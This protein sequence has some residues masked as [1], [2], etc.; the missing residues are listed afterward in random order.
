MLA[1][2]FCAIGGW[3]GHGAGGPCPHRTR[4]RGRPDGLPTKMRRVFCNALCFKIWP[5]ILKTLCTASEPIGHKG[6]TLF[7]IPKPGAD[8]SKCVGSRGVLAQ[9]ALA[10]VA[11]K[12]TR[13]I[14]VE[15][16]EQTGQSFRIGG[17]KGYCAGFGSLITRCFLKFARSM[18]L[19]ACDPLCRHYGG[20]LQPN[21][22]IGLW[23]RQVSLAR[24]HNLDIGTL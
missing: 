6:G 8:H 12:A 1:R 18:P 17:R 10:K 3:P 7:H 21:P 20:I 2:P 13:G 11:Q 15:R 23:R 16:L 9:S 4:P 22:G 5:L 19:H 24:Q 14:L